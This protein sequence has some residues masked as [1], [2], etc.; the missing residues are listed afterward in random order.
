MVLLD[1]S[2][3][4][5]EES[6]EELRSELEAI[7]GNTRLSE[8]YLQL[9]RDLDV[10]EAKTPEEVYKMHLVEGRGA[11]GPAVDSARHNLASTFVNAFVNAGFG[12]DKLVTA[13]PEGDSGSDVSLSSGC[14]NVQMRSSAICKIQSTLSTITH[15]V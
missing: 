11:D 10:M 14:L 12:N 8:H 2:S 15:L 5:N 9:A 7:N 6:N 3:G 1:H 4:T 13:A